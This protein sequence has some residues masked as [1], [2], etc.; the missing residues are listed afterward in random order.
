MRSPVRWLPPLAALAAAA[1]GAINVVSALTTDLP[2]RLAGF[3]V[4]AH[5]LTLPAGAALLVLSLYLA[6]RRRRALELAVGV[7]GLLATLELVRDTGDV[8]GAVASAALAGTLWLVRGAFTVRHARPS[9]RMAAAGSALFSVAVLAPL[10]LT[11]WPVKAAALSAVGTAA[12]A[13][14]LFRPLHVPAQAVSAA[15]QR[16]VRRLVHEHGADTLSAFKL[17]GDLARRWSADG[18]A[19]AGYRVEAGVLL[20]AGDPVGVPAAV[21]GLLR[22]LLADA[23]RHGLALGC[24]GASEAFAAQ[25]RAAGVRRLYLGDEAILPTGRMDLSGGAR[26]SLRKAVNRV[27]RHGFTAEVHEAGA[28]DAATLAALQAVSDGWRAGAPERGFS[29]A[30]DR[31]V[32]ELLPEALVVLGRDADGTVRGFLHFLPVF[33]RSAV[34]L[35]FMR[36]ERDT[37]NGLT[38]FLVVEAARLLGERGFAEFSLNFAAYGRW[39]REPGNVVER[40][41][42]VVL[43]RADALFQVERLL[44]FNQKFAPRWQPRYLLFERPSQLPRIALASMWAEGQLPKPALPRSSARSPVAWTS[45]PR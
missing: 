27:A 12:G 26:K 30:H 25:A 29:M 37:P 11:A 28:L 5:A 24:V 3:V 10:L 33:G 16:R 45:S 42:A 41:L 14:L 40:L 15:M 31:L 39:L 17:R 18:R 19:M 35:G 38:E 13:W 7:L 36:R 44:R 43:R 32:D 2:A 23:R 22:D 34:S 4:A 8:T 9:P 21:P 6:R 1:A 20:L